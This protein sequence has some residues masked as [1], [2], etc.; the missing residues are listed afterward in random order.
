MASRGISP[1]NWVWGKWGQNL[2]GHTSFYV[3][4]ID[5]GPGLKRD[6]LHQKQDVQRICA[7]EEEK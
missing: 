6:Q 4:G 1:F 5:K 7:K 2:K 3:P